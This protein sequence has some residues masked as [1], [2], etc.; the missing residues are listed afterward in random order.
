MWNHELTGDGEVKAGFAQSIIT[1]PLP[2]QLAGHRGPRIASEIADDLMTRAVALSFKDTLV[3]IVSCDIIWLPRRVVRRIRELVSRNVAVRPENLMVACTHTHSGPDTLGWYAFSPSI[4]EWWLEWLAHIISSTVFQAVRNIREADIS[5]GTADFP[6][7]VNRR[8]KFRG[9]IYRQ[10]SADGEVEDQVT[11]VTF[12]NNG[13]VIGG[14]IHAAM[15]PVVL[16]AD[17]PKISGDW[18]GEMVRRLNASIGGIWLFLNGCAGD[19]NPREGSGRT[20]DEMVEVGVRAAN[21][22]EDAIASGEVISIHVLH[23]QKDVSQFDAQPHPYLNVEQT[24]R[25]AEEG[26]LM[27]ECQLIQ[28]GP[29]TFIGM[30]GECLLESGRYLKSDSKQLVVSYSNDYVGY[31]ATSRSYDEGGYEPAASMLSKSGAADYLD[32]TKNQMTKLFSRICP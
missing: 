10:P 16:G 30:A 27:V 15:H 18:C 17:S 3:A 25:T 31:I 14:I 23:G 8:R 5:Y 13:R 26:G 19:N 28:L 21:C 4:P 2:V 6:L 1:P 29:V 11:A 7:A 9:I 24:R 22:A 20:Y 12:T 32:F